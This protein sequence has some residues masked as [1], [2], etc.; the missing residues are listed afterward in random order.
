[1]TDSE[2]MELDNKLYDLINPLLADGDENYQMNG[3]IEI[4]DW[5]CKTRNNIVNKIDESKK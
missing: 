4:F 3:D 2:F 5:Y 1:M